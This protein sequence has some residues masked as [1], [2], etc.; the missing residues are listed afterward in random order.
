MFSLREWIPQCRRGMRQRTPERRVGAFSTHQCARMAESG[1]GFKLHALC[2]AVLLALVPP[3]L[4]LWIPHVRCHHR[5]LVP[6]A[7]GS[8]DVRELRAEY[9]WRMVLALCECGMER[10]AAHERP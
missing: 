4:P 7:L 6:C 1:V 9:V 10:S 8:S 2:D 5:F 3:T